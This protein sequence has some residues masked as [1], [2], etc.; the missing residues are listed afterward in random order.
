MTTAGHV[1]SR[2]EI[3]FLIACVVAIVV[4]FVAEWLRGHLRG[5][6]KLPRPVLLAIRIVL[7]ITFLIL[8]VIGA[9]LPILQGWIFF[10]LAG[11]VLFPQS[12]F[13]IKACEK[14][15]PKMPRTIAWLR[16]RGIGTHR[17]MNP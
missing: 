3:G 9:L 15:E 17:E 12:R 6:G 7:G 5:G 1:W 11:L 16:R 8:G 14:I 2:L 13:A 10:L 4:I